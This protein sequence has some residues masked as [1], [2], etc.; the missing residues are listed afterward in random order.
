M[1]QDTSNN[2]VLTKPFSVLAQES[3]AE[4]VYKAPNLMKRILSLFKNVRP[5][6]D[7]THFQLPALFNLPKSTL[8]IYGEQVYS[9]STDL[10]SMCNK[11]KSPVDRLTS[12]VAWYISTK[13]PTIFGVVPYNPILG[14]THH[15]SKG[16]LNVLL[17]QVHLCY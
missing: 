10:L 15:V 2:I 9:T 14:E 5:G 11:G 8:Q 3:D 13:R 7:L 4:T 1:M 12:V 6:S 16:N 17:E